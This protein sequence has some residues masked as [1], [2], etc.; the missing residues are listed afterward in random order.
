MTPNKGVALVTD[1]GQGIGCAVALQLALDGY[2]I[3]LNDVDSKRPA[4]A[5]LASKIEQT[6]RRTHIVIDDVADEA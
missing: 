1:S 3:A 5:E 2:D 6:G 4:L